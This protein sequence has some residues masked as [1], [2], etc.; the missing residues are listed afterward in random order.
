MR[1]ILGFVSIQMLEVV[2]EIDPL[3]YKPHESLQHGMIMQIGIIEK[4]KRR[5]SDRS[6]LITF[7][8]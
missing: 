1:V 2:S 4:R 7:S 5:E 6:H 8:M 3:V